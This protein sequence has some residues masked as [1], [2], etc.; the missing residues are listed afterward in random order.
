MELRTDIDFDDLKPMDDIAALAPRPILI[1]HGAGDE[2]VPPGD[3]D[4]NFAAAREPKELWRLDGA[5]HGETV[6]PGGAASSER[7][8]AFFRRALEA[9]EA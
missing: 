2:S 1:I 6:A 4:Q 7:V 3:S 8:V 5:A 9:G